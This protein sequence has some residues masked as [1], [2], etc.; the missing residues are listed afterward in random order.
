[1]NEPPAV[2]RAAESPKG[3]HFL[4]T[5]PVSRF[6]LDQHDIGAPDTDNVPLKKFHSCRE[7]RD[8]GLAFLIR[9]Q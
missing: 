4:G 1:V 6:H 5:G 8:F 2:R 3:F 7:A 9:D